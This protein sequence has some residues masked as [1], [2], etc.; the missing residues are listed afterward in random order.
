M[1]L[2]HF[3]AA[4]KSPTIPAAPSGA[5]PLFIER[6]WGAFLAADVVEYSRLTSLNEEQTYFLYKSHRRELIDPKINEHRARFVKSTGDGIL[7]EFG[8]AL[9]AARCAV[10]VQQSM[11]ERCRKATSDCRIVFR[12][13]LSCGRIKPRRY[14]WPRSQC[15]GTFASHRAARRNRDDW[16]DCRTDPKH[17]SAA[18]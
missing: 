18:P 16:G 13:G 11:V 4:L 2:E 14:L 10:Q 9:D 3:T 1:R 7:A 8:S 15:G 5:I 12:I 17:P 6:R